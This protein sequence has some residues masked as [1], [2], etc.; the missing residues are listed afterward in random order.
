MKFSIGYIITAKTEDNTIKYLAM[1]SGYP[2]WSPT[3]ILNRPIF[4]KSVEEAETMLLSKDFTKSEVLGD[5][6]YPPSLIHSGANLNFSKPNGEVT[7][8]IMEV[9]CTSIRST[10]YPCSITKIK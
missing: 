6:L 4:F 3:I 1:D 5:N 9:E 10:Y 8:S 7:I 2:Y